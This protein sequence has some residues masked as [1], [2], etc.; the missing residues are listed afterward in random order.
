MS[1]KIDIDVI[2]ASGYHFLIMKVVFTP[3]LMNKKAKI[4]CFRFMKKEFAEFNDILRPYVECIN[5][6]TSI[7]PFFE[8]GKII[9]MVED[10]RSDAQ[11]IQQSLSFFEGL[12]K[13]S[14]EYIPSIRI[15]GSIT[16][17]EIDSVNGLLEKRHAQGLGIGIRITN[18][19]ESVFDYGFFQKLD[20]RD[21]LF[22]DLGESNYKTALFFLDNIKDEN[23][24][25]KVEI[26]SSERRKKKTNKN[27]CDF[28]K[29]PDI[30]TSV[31]E[32][33]RND[34][35]KEYGFATYCGYR[36]TINDGG[37]GMK[38]FGLILLMNFDDSSFFSIK[39]P[40]YGYVGT[41]YAALKPTILNNKKSV[42]S[43]LNANGKSREI[44]EQFL[45]GPNKG[46]AQFYIM[47]S[48]VHYIEELLY[49][50]YGV[51][52]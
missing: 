9:P 21:Y 33:L 40:V 24:R 44:L 36:S 31:L 22:I 39:S 12:E 45:E 37:K 46:T 42:L 48:M 10:R 34:S 14:G 3:I 13:D 25:V 27:Y 28:G 23:S 35:F 51:I 4:D 16:Q 11:S 41:T 47:L 29:E 15:H 1:K 30:N 19:L 5:E 7:E 17:E 20:H 32:A 49:K 50:Y 26:I 6:K 38:T 18:G 2:A 52:L 8:K 43:L